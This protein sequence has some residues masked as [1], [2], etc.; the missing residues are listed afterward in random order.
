[1]TTA[2]A[3]LTAAFA[4][5]YLAGTRLGVAR[6]RAERDDLTRRLADAERESAWRGMLL[7][8]RSP[9]VAADRRGDEPHWAEDFGPHE[10]PGQ[11]GWAAGGSAHP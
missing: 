10:P 1:M 6:V 7:A 2:A 5:G 3:L 4:A 9:E 8:R 11:D